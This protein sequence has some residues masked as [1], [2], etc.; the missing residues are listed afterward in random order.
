MVTSAPSAG[1]TRRNGIP[2]AIYGV[3]AGMVATA[4]G[5]WVSSGTSGPGR[6]VIWAVV[7]T[8]LAVAAA[9]FAV[10]AVTVLMRIA[11]FELNRRRRVSRLP[12]VF[13][14]ASPGPG[15]SA[16]QGAADRDHHGPG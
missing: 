11:G 10:P 12:V 1:N 7:S 5:A 9:W 15:G 6:L 8:A 3:E 16:Q 4:A 2:L 14:A 13:P